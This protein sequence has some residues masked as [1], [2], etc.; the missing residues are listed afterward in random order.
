[1]QFSFVLRSMRHAA[2]VLHNKTKQ[3]NH[4]L[5][6]HELGVSSGHEVGYRADLALSASVEPLPE[7]AVR[8]AVR[9]DGVH[10]LHTADIN[11]KE[12]KQPTRADAHIIRTIS[13]VGGWTTCFTQ[14]IF[15]RRWR[16]RKTGREKG[17]G[18]DHATHLGLVKGCLRLRL[19]AIV[20]AG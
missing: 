20:Q 1:M 17:G 9:G 2:A 16:V 11:R 4:N 18:S 13:C 14:K 12:R 19:D 8:Y 6:G 10:H 7:A 5:H 3:M 15:R